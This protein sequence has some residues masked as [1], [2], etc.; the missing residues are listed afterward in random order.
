MKRICFHDY[1]PTDQLQYEDAEKPVAGA[2][3]LLV[4]V[5]AVSVN[6]VDWKIGSGAARAVVTDPLP[7]VPGGDLAGTVEAVGEG[8][9]GWSAGDEVYAQ[10]GLWGAYADYVAIDAD[11]AAR[12]PSNLNFAEAASLPLVAL[13]L[14][15]GFEAD[16]RDL[17]GLNVLIHNAAGGVGS[18]AVQYAKA[19]GARV[20]GTA[21]AKNADFVKGL[22]A[23]E[24][25]DFRETPVASRTRDID[26]L[27][28]L[29]GNPAALELW[30]LVKPG[31]SVVRIAGGADAPAFA[32]D[33]GIRALKVRV[34]PNG[35]QLG[36][37]TDLV[38][39]GALKPE[40]ARI[41]PLSAAADA[42]ELSKT[43]RVRG[44]IVLETG[45]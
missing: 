22:G 36:R 29:V 18:I 17:A 3:Q 44:K 14:L 11:A 8:V 19:L 20:V 12:K 35:A 43:G 26:I 38:E 27:M 24:V 5:A 32:E 10:I 6:P 2:G 37:I 39:Q 25:V 30:A 9:T 28:D 15:Q 34:R 45:A 42:Q 33:D 41:F 4:K 7:L 16:G 40:V 31:G 13:T 23:D 21:S 1:G